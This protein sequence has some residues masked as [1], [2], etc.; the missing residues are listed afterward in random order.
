MC[1]VVLTAAAAGAVMAQ[2]PEERL[3]NWN[4]A[5][6]PGGIPDAGPRFCDVRVGIPGSSLVAAGNGGV[7]DAPAI[8]VAL[9]LCPPG[10]H[11]YLPPGLYRIDSTLEYPRKGVVLKGAGP[12]QT[13]IAAYTPTAIRM[14]GKLV[15]K[16]TLENYRA[17]AERDSQ[18]LEFGSSLSIAPAQAGDLLVVSELPDPAFVL[19]GGRIQTKELVE[20]DFEWRQ[21]ATFPAHYYVRRAGGGD[22]Q[23]I[24]GQML[25][26][27]ANDEIPI[28]RGIQPPL[29]PG[30]WAMGDF[31]TPGSPSVYVRLEGDAAPGS[32]PNAKICSVA[33]TNWGMIRHDVGIA[34]HG[35]GFTIVGKDGYRL[36]LDRP[37]LWTFAGRDIEFRLFGDVITGMGLEDLTI[38]VE[39]DSPANSTVYMV[40]VRRSWIRN[41]H[42]R[43]SSQT[44]IHLTQTADCVLH[45]NLVERPRFR[46]GGSGYGIRLLGWNFHTL[47]ENN[48]AYDMRHS[49]VI[50]GMGAGNVFAYN[51]SL[52]PNDG[53]QYLYQDILSHGPHPMFTLFE[54]NTAANAV[55]DTVHGSASHSMYFRNALRLHE[56]ARRT[57]NKSLGA[58]ALRLDRWNRYMIAAG[59]VLGHPAMSADLPNAVYEGRNETVYKLGYDADDADPAPNDP[60]TA[61]TLLRHGNHDYVTGETRWDDTLPGR[62]LPASLYLAGKPGWFGDLPWPPTGPDREPRVG[63]IP[64]Q[65][66]FEQLNPP[67]E[68]GE[69]TLAIEAA[70]AAWD[71]PFTEMDGAISQSVGTLDVPG[72]RAVF[73]FSLA[74]PGVFFVKA[75]VDAPSGG[76][77]SFF[78][79]MNAEPSTGGDVWDIMPYTMGPEYRTVAARGGGSHDL[80]QFEPRAFDLQAG[81]N[82]LIVRG[83]E[84]NTRIHRVELWKISGLQKPSPPRNVRWLR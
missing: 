33:S 50:D 83:R 18:A 59:N 63:I 4:M 79:A 40:H 47:V 57:Y 10:Q 12:Q 75:L 62:A 22:P 11:V 20:P 74:E 35:Q 1:A 68:E 69:F 41:V 37:F 21:S 25:L 60:L 84:P 9:D 54:G 5:G 77:N 51:F 14:H 46:G 24:P 19:G 71:P 61:S 42:I 67:R 81:S 39:I 32:D 45:G 3:A 64:A 34:H 78:V 13:R 38:D 16:G 73:S 80:P 2:L 56:G 70:N 8:Q 49:Y 48:A 6:I 82:Q 29:V 27:T 30:Q 72:G 53:S 52:D 26:R 66:R 55:A 58:V 23:L 31:D 65:Q 7:D 76:S 17:G 15:H 28:E 43:R 36:E 44:S